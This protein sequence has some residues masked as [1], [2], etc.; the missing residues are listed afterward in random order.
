[1]SST[2]HLLCLN[3]TPALYASRDLNRDDLAG[4]DR[5]DAPG[6]THCDL[7]ITRTS[8]DLVEVGCLGVGL[9]GPTGCHSYHPH[10]QWTDADWLRLL[11]TA[12]TTGGA[13]PDLLRRFHARCW[14]PERLHA[15]AE[16]LGMPRMKPPA[17]A[18]AARGAEAV[19]N[20]PVR[21]HHP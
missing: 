16:E 10:I 1:M 5:T 19:P 8:G 12:T 14:T 15:L 20:P 17:Q 4:I 3:H 9:D 11:H 18:A 21:D 7:V 13:S 6:H 2:Y